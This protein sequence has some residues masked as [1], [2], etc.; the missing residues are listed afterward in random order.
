MS[1]MK[2]LLTVALAGGIL[3]SCSTHN[4][5]QPAPDMASAFTIREIMQ[6][7][8]SPR[9][10]SIWNAVAT[11]VTDKGPETKAP[12]NDEE[13][14]N[15]RYEAVTLSEGMNSILAP[16]RKVAKPGDVAKDPKAELNPEQIEVLINKDRESWAKLAHDLQ[17][18]V[19]GAI[20]AIDAKN[21]E[22]LSNAG[23]GIDTACETCHKKY[24]YPNDATA[25]K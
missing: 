15:L 6:S 13:W 21:A 3:T 11:S 7:M 23:G 1:A 19:K 4:A 8:V 10:D 2:T 20:D 18:A 22:A 9:A 24:W 17:G 5:A 16:G 12:K 25:P 14:A